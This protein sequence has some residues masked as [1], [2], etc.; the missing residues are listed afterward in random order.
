[1]R[2]YN[3]PKFVASLLIASP[4]IACDPDD[5]TAKHVDKNSETEGEEV[6]AQPEDAAEPDPEEDLLG[7]DPCSSSGDDR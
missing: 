3:L 5:L 7:G 2:T 6:G 4:L 1:M